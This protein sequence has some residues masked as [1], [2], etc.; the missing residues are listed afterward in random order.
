MKMHSRMSRWCLAKPPAHLAY[1]MALLASTHGHLAEIDIF[2]DAVF[3]HFFF[4]Q[5][6]YNCSMKEGNKLKTI[7]KEV[8]FKTYFFN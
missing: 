1:G 6:S 5:L 2:H 4:K 7:L 3:L 8:E